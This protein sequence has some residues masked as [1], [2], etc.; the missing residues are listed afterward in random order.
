M[1]SRSLLI[2]LIVAIIVLLIVII[3]LLTRRNVPA[4]RAGVTY[5]VTKTGNDSNP[6]SAPSPCLTIGTGLSKLASGDTLVIHAGTYNE[7][8]CNAIPSGVNASNPTIVMANPGD[9]V[10]V[11]G[12]AGCAAAVLFISTRSYI[13][14]QNINWDVQHRSGYMVVNVAS[15]NTVIMDG[16]KLIDG[17]L[18]TYYEGGPPNTS[19][20]LQIKNME[21]YGNYCLGDPSCP[22]G[23]H[24]IYITQPN[25]VVD[26][27]IIHDNDGHG[28][29]AYEGST[30]VGL[31][32]EII[33][34]NIIYNNGTAGIRAADGNND[35]VYNNLIYNN[36]QV[37]TGYAGIMVKTGSGQK[38]WNN[39]IYGQLGG[40]G[41]FVENTDSG[42]VIQNNIQYMNGASNYT[43]NG[44]GT[45]HD[46]NLDNG[47]DPQFVNAGAQ[48]FQ[49][50]TM[51]PAKDAGITLSAVIR[52]IIGVSRPQGPSYDMGAYEYMSG[53]AFTL[54]RAL[55]RAPMVGNGSPSGMVNCSPG[56]LFVQLDGTANRKLWVCPSINTW[57]QQ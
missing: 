37:L 4:P 2:A 17:M 42:A 21:I 33:T 36:G 46:H 54:V 20:N 1:N 28:I 44:S 52:D 38:I 25:S 9:T 11:N 18:S 13:T 19:T 45:T 57:E 31:D 48:N 32:N 53:G 16:G 26:H 47:T 30:G 10:L 7:G 15:S 43:D 5:H 6:C 49:L 27:N 40:Y 35:Q 56:D 3:V 34:G 39:T 41:I 24:A 14:I 8:V 50:N 29:H 55:S 12:T 23:G 22:Q 51:S